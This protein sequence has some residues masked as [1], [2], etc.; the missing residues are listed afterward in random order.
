MKPPRRPHL[1][2]LVPAL[3]AQAVTQTAYTLEHERRTTRY[4]DSLPSLPGLLPATVNWDR[5]QQT[6]CRDT[7]LM[8]DTTP[9]YH[10]MLCGA[11]ALRKGSPETG[12]GF[13]VDD[14]MNYDARVFSLSN[15]G[16]YGRRRKLHMSC[17][18]AL[19]SS[20]AYR[21][22]KHLQSYRVDGTSQGK[23][24]TSFG[25]IGLHRIKDSTKCG[26]RCDKP[27]RNPLHAL[28]PASVQDIKTARTFRVRRC[29]SLDKLPVNTQ[30]KTNAQTGRTRS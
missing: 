28:C 14:R 20:N 1:I 24:P 30:A 23:D 9:K 19:E 16:P 3:P 6:P 26:I 8:H 10:A 2:A 13:L 11:A 18:R 21:N 22:R 27:T 12:T 4:N 29:N 7:L 17:Q 25:Q 15:T 5:T